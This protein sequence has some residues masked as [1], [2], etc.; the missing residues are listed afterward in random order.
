[1]EETKKKS[2]RFL[3]ETIAWYQKQY[4]EIQM[5]PIKRVGGKEIL[6]LTN[7]TKMAGNIS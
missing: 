7:A 5:T 2:E 1:M 6:Q 4:P 3:N